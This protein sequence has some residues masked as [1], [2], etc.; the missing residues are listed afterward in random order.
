MDQKRRTK[1]SWVV[2][3]VAALLGTYV[4]CNSP[5]D[6]DIGL[7]AALSA[8]N[9]SYALPSGTDVRLNQ[10][11]IK[12]SSYANAPQ[13]SA[14]TFQLERQ[15]IRYLEFKMRQIQPGTWVSQ[16]AGAPCERLEECLRQVVVW[17][18][19]EDQHAPLFVAIGG[20]FAGANTGV[21]TFEDLENTILGVLKRNNILT[22]ADAIAFAAAPRW[23]LLGQIKSKIVLVLDDI[24]PKRDV[25]LSAI[26]REKA[27][28]F[29]VGD[30]LT[31][32]PSAARIA[33]VDNPI[34]NESRIATLVSRGFLVR[35]KA[36]D[37]PSLS[38]ETDPSAGLKNR[39][40]AALSSGA[41]LITSERPCP[42]EN[43]SSFAHSYCMSFP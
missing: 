15:G 41:Q 35:T 19:Q 32:M 40:V 6:F 37:L 30:A 22:P 38:T 34:G 16:E 28:L 39:L 8:N 33:Y 27:L 21:G 43:S 25:Y 17:A 9:S 14:L 5:G 20:D 42:I 29:V 11:Q 12:G 7:A 18:M 31:N 2:W 13:K 3:L 26:P 4:A 24:G 10:V 36:D 23:P 1:K